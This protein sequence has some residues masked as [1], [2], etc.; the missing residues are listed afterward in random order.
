MLALPRSRAARAPFASLD[1][2]VRAGV[3]REGSALSALWNM[4]ESPQ[5]LPGLFPL[6]VRILSVCEFLS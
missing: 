2:S 3:A 4:R 6:A 5:K 1:L